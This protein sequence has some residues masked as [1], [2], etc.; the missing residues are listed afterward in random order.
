MQRLMLSFNTLR[1]LILPILCSLMSLNA[2]G[3][4]AYNDQIDKSNK[5]KQWNVLFVVI[6]DLNTWT[7]HLNTHQGAKTPNIDRLANKGVSFRHAYSPVPH[8][9]PARTAIMTGLRPWESGIY[10]GD[11]D[12]FSTIKNTVTIPQYFAGHGYQTIGTGKIFHNGKQGHTSP[13]YW[14][15]YQDFYDDELTIPE[16]D[17]FNRTLTWG[18]TKQTEEAFADHKRVDWAI[19]KIKQKHNKPFFLAVGIVKPHLG[20]NVPNKYFDLHPLESIVLPSV[21]ENDL[22]DIPTIGKQWAKNVEDTFIDDHKSVLAADKWREGVQGYLA[23]TSFADA[24]FGRL[25]DGLNQSEHKDNTIIVLWGD[26][27]WHLGQKQHWRKHTLWEEA[28]ATSYIIY[29]PG[30]K[31]QGRIDN[32]PVDL[33]S[34]YPILAELTNLPEPK[35]SG[36]SLVPLLKNPNMDWETPAIMSYFHGNH[37]VRQGQYRYIRYADGTEE[38]YDHQIDPFEWHNLQ[39]EHGLTKIKQKMAAYLR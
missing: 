9:K 23:G 12:W 7:G 17:R 22:D 30:L 37:A 38:L 34:I 11:Q 6:D 4:S 18:A 35:H 31:N 27:G 16:S 10:H 36:I 26:H 5:Q 15:E 13:D 1:Y 33:M 20:W 39:A 29:V 3:E 24:Q 14:Q 8:C 2:C 25:L 28:T 19:N 21:L 32:T